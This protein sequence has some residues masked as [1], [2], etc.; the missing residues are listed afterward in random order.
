MCDATFTFG[1]RGSHF[2]QCPSRSEQ[3]VA[4]KI[5]IIPANISST[6]LPR[7]LVNILNSSKLKQIHHVALGY[8]DT[9]LCTWR[10]VSNQDK[11]DSTGL[12]LELVKFIHAQNSQG[13]LSRDVPNLRCVLGPY[14]DSYYVHDGNAYS[15]MNLPSK[16][17]GSL[18]LRIE[19]GN[20]TDRPRLVALGAGGDFVLLTEK[21]EAIW[22]LP[23]YEA[24]STLL[25]KFKSRRNGIA[26]IQALILHA[27]RYQSFVVQSKSGVLTYE[28]LPV[29]SV[30]GMR[31]MVKH[32]VDD[33]KAAEWKPLE[34]KADTVRDEVPKRPSVLQ[35]RAS[36]RREWSEHS[37]EFATQ[38]RGIKVSLSLSIGLGG[39][40]RALG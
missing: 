35:Q 37:Q 2:F 15:W 26:E 33:T 16:L 39:L 34:R 28:N 29:P 8:E 40:A 17:L 38:T 19:N 32:V 4:D 6:Q 12:P 31:A 5:I 25:Q 23:N 11:I 10:D 30:A 9:F 7:K 3:Y 18:E 20:W 27:H 21:H 36:L 24:A 1:Q 13:R 14:N 22:D